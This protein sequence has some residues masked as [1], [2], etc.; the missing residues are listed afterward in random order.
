MLSSGELASAAGTTTRTV[1]H[2][3][4]I[5][6]LPEPAR[7]TNGYR[8]YDVQAVLRLVRI[9]RL[10]Q[11]GL[12]LPKIEQALAGA[13]EQDLRAMLGELVADLTRQEAEIREQRERLVALLAR[14]HDLALPSGLAEVFGEVRRLLPAEDALVRREGELLEL[15]EATT[16]PELFSG[17]SALHRSA[18][19][20]PG[21]VERSTALARRV[22]ALTSVDPAD[23]EVA[24]VAAEV[25]AC[26]REGFASPV[27][28]VAD[29]TSDRG[30][31]WA[32]YLAALAPAQQRC[33]ALADQDYHS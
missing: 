22:E 9:R 8:T 19:A 15:I 18:L 32:A 1:R 23:P 12:S 10:T 3:H 2:H 26:A 33:M 16:C 24:T 21:V 17:F 13:D 11:L 30:R 14:E 7:R 5:G 29:A 20:D 6:L 25:V 28:E 27:P 4:T 31:V